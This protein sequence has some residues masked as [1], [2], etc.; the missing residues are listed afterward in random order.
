MTD[1]AD[2]HDRLLVVGRVIHGVSKELSDFCSDLPGLKLK[3][4]SVEFPA[5]LG[6]YRKKTGMLMF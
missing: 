3:I 4:N 1:V 2:V 6:S 5:D